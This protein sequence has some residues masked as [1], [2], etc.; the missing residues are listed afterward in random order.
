[1][2]ASVIAAEV[3]V[4]KNDKHQGEFASDPIA[5][6]VRWSGSRSELPTP[7]TATEPEPKRESDGSRWHS[8]LGVHEQRIYFR[9]SSLLTRHELIEVRQWL[10]SRQ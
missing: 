4:T 5:I 2:S 3:E 7:H 1:M 9:T 6:K 10:L 8:N